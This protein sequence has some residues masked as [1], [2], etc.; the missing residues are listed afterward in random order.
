MLRAAEKARA[1]HRPALTLLAV[2]VLTSLD[3]PALNETGVPGDAAAQVVR[4]GK[5][6]RNAGIG[7]LVCSPL[8]LPVLRRELGPEPLLV[9]PGVR[10]AGAD[11]NEQKRVM[12]PGEA[13]R[14]GASLIVVGRPILQAHEPAAAA[15]KIVQELTSA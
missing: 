8:E 6:A 15:R 14:A 11:A 13:A 7:G 3:T 9:T 5:L 4:L 12:T 1:A 10:P 2:T